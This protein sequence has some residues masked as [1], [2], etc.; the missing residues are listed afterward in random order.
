[1]NVLG[2]ESEILNRLISEGEVEAARSQ[3]HRS[4]LAEGRCRQ[5]RQLGGGSKARRLRTTRRAV[6][7]AG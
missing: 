4:W 5:R 6:G 3:P 1:M 7:A 2:K